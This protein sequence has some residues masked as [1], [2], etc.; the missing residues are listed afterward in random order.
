MVVQEASVDE[1]GV[2]WSV[3]V[4]RARGVGV[5]SCSRAKV[6]CEVGV[7]CEREII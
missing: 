2:F 4:R 6:V 5:W 1:R 3:D 7:D